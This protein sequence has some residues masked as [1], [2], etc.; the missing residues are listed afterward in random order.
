MIVK[1]SALLFLP[2]LF[3]PATAIKLRGSVSITDDD[4]C[5]LKDEKDACITSECEW[6]TSSASDLA[7]KCYSHDTAKEFPTGTV[8]ECSGNNNGSL[9]EED[10]SSISTTTTKSVEYEFEPHVTHT[11]TD[12]EVDPN[13]CDPTSPHSYSGYM[14]VS[15]SKYDTSKKHEK[16]YFFWMFESRHTETVKEGERHTIPLVIWLTG[17]PGCSSTLALLKENG[18]CTVNED[19]SGTELNKF[20]WN[21]KAHVLWLDQPAGVGFSYG[22]END[23]NE[24]MVGEDAYYFLQSFVKTHPEYAKNPLFVTGESYGGHYVPAIADRIMKGNEEKKAGTQFLNLKGVALG[25]GLTNPEIQYQSYAEMAYK[26]PHNIKAVPGLVYEGMRAATSTCASMIHEC[27][28]SDELKPAQ[29]VDCMSATDYCNMALVMPYQISGRNVYDIRLKCEKKPLCYDFSNIETF[30]NLKSTRE[31]LHVSH[32]STSHWKS[33][34]MMV[35]MK[36]TVDMM[37]DMSP[38][39][40]NLLN[41]DIKVL[42]YAGDADFIC[43]YKGNRAWTMALEWDHTTEFNAAEDE[44][45]NDGKGVMRSAN[46]LTFLQVRDAGHMVPMDQPEVALKMLNEFIYPNDV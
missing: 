37:M 1:Q 42:V 29:A 41:S 19:G 39:V 33:C 32:K 13:L 35:H 46:G 5:N 43:N 22:K 15:G 7:V 16:N 24:D 10:D 34:N 31:A 8:F 23:G 12:G 44:D 26:N 36:F 45:W 20:G 4:I 6:C 18:P 2:F 3:N 17:G 11:L 30:M 38:H 9:K 27:A 25:N 21:E 14:S 28:H 40:T